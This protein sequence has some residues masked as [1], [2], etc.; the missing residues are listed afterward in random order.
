MTNKKSQGN[1]QDFLNNLYTGSVSAL[2]AMINAFK[3]GYNSGKS[4]DTVH[5][6]DAKD[7]KPLPPTGYIDKDFVRQ[8]AYPTVVSTVDALIADIT[9]MTAHG[10]H[11]T[12]ARQCVVYQTLP[13]K[14]T[15]REMVD[16]YND[17]GFINAF[18]IADRSIKKFKKH[19]YI[20]YFPEESAWIKLESLKK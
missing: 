13:N 17:A 18:T 15:Y 1:I 3:Y 20:K 10:E 6:V 5:E 16:I 19:G 7:P 9:P 2:K 4:K 12:S 11:V 8:D 14:F